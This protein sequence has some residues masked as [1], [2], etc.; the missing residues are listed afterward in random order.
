M[1]NTYQYTA[2]I[3]LTRAQY[4]FLRDRYERREGISADKLMQMAILEAVAE[5]ARKRLETTGYHVVHESKAQI[6]VLGEN[7]VQITE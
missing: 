7:E 6:H 5:Q 1:R 3:R 2:T 4:A